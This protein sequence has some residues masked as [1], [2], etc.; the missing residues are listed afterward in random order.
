MMSE[1][2]AEDEVARSYLLLGIG[3]SGGPEDTN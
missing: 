3:G 2:S 1:E